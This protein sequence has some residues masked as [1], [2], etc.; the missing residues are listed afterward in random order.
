[1]SNLRQIGQ[2]LLLYSI[3]HGRLPPDLGTMA[4]DVDLH[5]SVFVC[6][7]GA[8]PSPPANFDDLPREQKIAWINKNSH[9]IYFADARINGPPDTVIVHEKL[10]NHGREGINILYNDGHVEWHSRASAVQEIE[11]NKPKPNRGA[12]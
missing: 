7:T 3:D 11:R 5:P 9:Y 8:G 6:P 4:V 12:Q 10:D 2:G 1:M